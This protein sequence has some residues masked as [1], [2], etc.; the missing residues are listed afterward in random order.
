[1]KIL[2]DEIQDWT[3]FVFPP[4]CCYWNKCKR[5]GEPVFK[6][7]PDHSKP[8]FTNYSFG[9][10]IQMV[11]N[12]GLVELLSQCIQMIFQVK[13]FFIEMS[14]N[15]W[16]G[17]SSCTVGPGIWIML[18]RSV[19]WS[20]TPM[21]SSQVKLEKAWGLECRLLM[22]TW[23]EAFNPRVLCCKMTMPFLAHAGMN[24]L[25]WFTMLN[26]TLSLFG[27]SLNFS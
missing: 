2:C 3:C 19:V 13:P 21:G 14:N 20:V 1:M 18:K 23:S 25:K 7:N 8:N 5:K 11:P 4:G 17:Q 10:V 22:C 27:R 15:Y 12:W 24:I 6:T 9:S 26:A 16:Q